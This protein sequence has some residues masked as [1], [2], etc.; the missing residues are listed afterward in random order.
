L[1]GITSALEDVVLAAGITITVS[2]ARITRIIRPTLCP[3]TAPTEVEIGGAQFF[4]IREPNLDAASRG[5]KV[6][7][8]TPISVRLNSNL[9]S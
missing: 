7:S 1:A 4:V 9:M 6:D 3:T 2:V 5:I 8:T